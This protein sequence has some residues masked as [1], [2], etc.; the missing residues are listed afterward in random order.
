MIKIVSI[1]TIIFLGS[2]ISFSSA[3][4]GPKVEE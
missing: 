3:R 2:V 4:T 1:L